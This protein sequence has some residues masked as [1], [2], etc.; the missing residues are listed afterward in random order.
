ML[1]HDLTWIK[2]EKQRIEEPVAWSLEQN[3]QHHWPCPSCC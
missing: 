2:V 3:E 1:Q